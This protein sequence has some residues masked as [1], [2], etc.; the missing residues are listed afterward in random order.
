VGHFGNINHLRLKTSTILAV[1]S[2]LTLGPLT[3]IFLLLQPAMS[4]QSTQSPLS[5]GASWNNLKHVT[6]DRGY[7]VI[8]RDQK[9]VRGVINSVT[10]DT[11]VL[12]NGGPTTQVVKRED[13]LRVSDGPGARN[14]VFNT[15]SSWTDVKEAMPGWKEYLSIVTK[16][17]HTL[18][19][20][21]PTVSDDSISFERKTV[22]KPQI[23][24]VS[25]VRYK[26]LTSNE[27]YFHH[28]SADLFAPRLWFHALFL[29]TI[30]VPL[31]DSALVEDN[32]HIICNH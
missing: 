15:R 10:D 23:Q 21:Q 19:W 31:Y 30:T 1:T 17:G 29:G 26:P 5:L 9:C 24:S 2:I 27:E 28:R 6:W 13:V 25:Y 12:S 7:E 20:K 14:T 22:P 18:D 8:L 16:D 11:L 32:S 3:T 4:G